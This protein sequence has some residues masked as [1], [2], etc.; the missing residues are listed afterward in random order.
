MLVPLRLRGDIPCSI[1]V[2]KIFI[3]LTFIRNGGIFFYDKFHC[4]SFKTCL[5]VGRFKSQL[6][7]LYLP[8]ESTDLVH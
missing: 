8:K 4:V 1:R 6:S 5:P 7:K 2:P 3:V